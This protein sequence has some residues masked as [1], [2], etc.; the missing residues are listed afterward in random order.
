[1]PRTNRVD[2]ANMSYHVI[3]RTNA[4]VQIF[5]NNRDYKLFEDI[6]EGA[7]EKFEMRILSYCIM[8]NHWHLSLY[9]KKDGDLSKF[10]GWIT[11]THTRRWHATK[12]GG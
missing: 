7:K 5:D 6:L 8:P 10:M 11:N 2:V 9:P 4:R 12:N 3:N 1:M